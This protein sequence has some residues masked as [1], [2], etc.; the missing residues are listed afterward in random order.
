RV[1]K[2]EA[3]RRFELEKGYLR[4]AVVIKKSRS[5]HVL[6]IVM[7]HI[8]SDGWSLGIM[9]K[10][11]EESYEKYRRG[12]AEEDKE[13]EVQYI[14]YAIWERRKGEQEQSR[15]KRYWREQLKGVK[16]VRIV[17]QREE[18]GEEKKEGGKEEV[19][20]GKEVMEGIRKLS[21]QEG[22][23]LFISLLAAFQVLLHRWTNSTDIIVG[24]DLANRNRI[25]IESLIGFFVNILPLRTD[26]SGDP[27]FR[28]ALHRVRGVVLGAYTHQEI[29]FTKLVESLQLERRFGQVPLIQVIFVLQNAPMPSLA[30][31]GLTLKHLEIDTKTSRF[32]LGLFVGETPKGLAGTWRY[33]TNLFDS[34]TIKLLSKQFVTLLSSIVEQPD[35]RIS[36]LRI[37]N[38]SE[39]EQQAAD[40]QDAKEA[41]LRK[42]LS[43]KPEAVRLSDEVSTNSD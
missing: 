7:H 37:F 11:M 23:T 4:R 20:V 36:R 19:E 38:D 13:K 21:R 18:R 22:A 2:E 34:G 39:I 17:E 6:A 30:L 1:I 28:E 14:D 15:E 31:T 16:G 24:T 27:T 12:E 25:E 10:E 32:E 9:V 5:E 40:K 43:T 42:L 26:L 41:R 33:D 3:G 35:V 8:I 29:P